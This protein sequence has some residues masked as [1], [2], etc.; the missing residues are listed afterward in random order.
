MLMFQPDIFGQ[1]SETRQG[2]FFYEDKRFDWY[3]CLFQLMPQA[4]TFISSSDYVEP[5][6]Y[7][8]FVAPRPL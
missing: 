7:L 2:L 3:F 8:S 5:Q 1:I 6:L 4:Y